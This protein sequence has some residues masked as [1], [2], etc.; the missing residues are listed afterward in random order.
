MEA[1]Y[2]RREAISSTPTS[3]DGP[4]LGDLTPQDESAEEPDGG[5][6]L[7]RIW[8]GPWPGNP[9]GLLDRVAS[10]GENVTCAEMVAAV[11]KRDI[12]ISADTPPEIVAG[13]RF[14]VALTIANVSSSAIHIVDVQPALG[15]DIKSA[16]LDLVT[17][18]SQMTELEAKTQRL[19]GEMQRQVIFANSQT[20]AP[21]TIVRLAFRIASIYLPF[22][23]IMQDDSDRFREALKIEEWDDVVR[24]EKGVHYAT[25]GR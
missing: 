14:R 20:H 24:L 13:K 25:Q 1:L 16:G 6:L 21:R 7:V 2:R 3:R 23:S 10:P 12:E 15:F 8:R 19:K 22:Y 17:E 4:A 9:A 18:P 11:I 5:N